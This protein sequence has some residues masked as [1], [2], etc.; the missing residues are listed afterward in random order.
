[1]SLQSG[2]YIVDT[3]IDNWPTGFEDA[4]KLAVI[5]LVEEMIEKITRDYFYNKAFTKVLNGTGKSRIWLHFNPDILGVSEVKFNE[6]VLEDDL[7]AFDKSSIFRATVTTAQLQAI[8]DITL[9]G[10][11][12]V[13]VDATGHGFI[14]GQIAR[15]ISMVG[16]TPDLA[17]DY[18]VVKIDDDALTLNGTD[19][20]DYSGSFTSG[21]LIFASLA[22]LVYQTNQQGGLFPKGTM[23][24]EVTG[25][26]GWVTT[27][28]AIRQAAI[29]LARFENDGTLYTKYD[30]LVSDKL[31]DATA[32]RG[33]KTYLTGIHE[34]DRLIRRY[35]RKKSLI[36]AV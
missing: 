34:A 14:T 1:M 21:N 27:P 29:I 36:N 8:E 7:Y 25:T 16:I 17:G 9:S 24:I 11:D 10:S 18:G 22:E 6:V 26:Y 30:D 15:L 2:N 35:I 31:G 12:P 33:Q 4:D 3:D 32:N 5:E 20:S 28:R 19:S 23:N 13:Q